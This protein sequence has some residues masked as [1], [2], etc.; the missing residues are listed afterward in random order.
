MENEVQRECCGTCR[1][2]NKC[3]LHC[4]IEILGG[5]GSITVLLYQKQYLKT[6]CQNLRK[7]S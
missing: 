4:V 1:K 5:E 6:Q 2:Y 7:K 3:N